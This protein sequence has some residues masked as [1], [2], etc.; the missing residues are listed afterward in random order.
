MK[1]LI[2]LLSEVREEALTLGKYKSKIREMDGFSI[3]YGYDPDRIEFFLFLKRHWGIDKGFIFGS[4]IGEDVKIV[5]R[6]LVEKM[7]GT[8]TGHDS[9]VRK[10]AKWKEKKK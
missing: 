4:F 2:S 9:L 6:G 3:I 7:L 10:V 5:A 1:F 8:R